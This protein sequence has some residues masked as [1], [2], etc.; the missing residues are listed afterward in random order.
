MSVSRTPSVRT[1]PHAGPGEA[2]AHRLVGGDL[3]AQFE[4]YGGSPDGY[5]ESLERLN[6]ASA[7]DVK[8]A[9]ARWPQV[10]RPLIDVQVNM[11][12]EHVVVKFL[13]VLSHCL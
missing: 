13:G 8:S 6:A 1:G 9:G 5:K 12:H 2:I 10:D 3:L 11:L 4:V 7:S